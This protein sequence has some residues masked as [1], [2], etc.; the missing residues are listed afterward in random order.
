MLNELGPWSLER[1]KASL[2][3][4]FGLPCSLMALTLYN[5]MRQ[6]SKFSLAFAIAN[7]RTCRIVSERILKFVFFFTD[8]QSLQRTI[9]ILMADYPDVTRGRHFFNLSLIY[10]ESCCS[11][12]NTL[13]VYC[14]KTTSYY[15]LRYFESESSL[16]RHIMHC[17]CSLGPWLS[18]CFHWHKQP[19]A[20]SSASCWHSSK[21]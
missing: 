7:P 1:D 13:S 18:S 9:I 16:W 6:A 17:H 11:W 14:I 10:N 21:L 19:G 12:Q 4:H 5:Q 8:C 15:L 2:T 20:I 3:R